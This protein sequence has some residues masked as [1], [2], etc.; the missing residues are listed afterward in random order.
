MISIVFATESPPTDESPVQA[1][2]QH[3]GDDEVD[4]LPAV[5]FEVQEVYGHSVPVLQDKDANYDT[6]CEETQYGSRYLP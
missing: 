1:N 2:S 3:N 6:E 5:N 4:P